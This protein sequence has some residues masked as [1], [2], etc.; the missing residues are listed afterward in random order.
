VLDKTGTLTLGR[1]RVVDVLP[2]AEEDD[3]R[4]LALAAAA[5]RL[6]GHP[7]AEAVVA[8]ARR[9]D[10]EIPLAGALRR[11]PARASGHRSTGTWCWWAIAA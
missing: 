3:N 7:L 2:A 6:S 11:F 5:E 8:H 1:H 4:W 10:L 9:L